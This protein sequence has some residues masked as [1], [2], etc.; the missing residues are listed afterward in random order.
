MVELAFYRTKKVKTLEWI[1]EQSES[2]KETIIRCRKNLRTMITDKGLEL[3]P[4]IV[5]CPKEDAPQW[6]VRPCS[7]RGL[8]KLEVKCIK[9]CVDVKVYKLKFR[10]N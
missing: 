4:Q 7:I 6:D 10:V 2:T 8:K 3:I 9:C 5:Q 1:L